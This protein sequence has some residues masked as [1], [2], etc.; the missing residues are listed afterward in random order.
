MTSSPW[1]RCRA[2]AA[3]GMTHL[4]ASVDYRVPDYPAPTFL[5]IGNE[6]QGLPA[7]YAA[8]ADVRVKIPMR[9]RADS[10]NAAVACAVMAYEVLGRIEGSRG[11]AAS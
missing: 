2:G 11:P 8:A 1:L 3:R 7:D 9:G 4:E 10:L 5:L 6:A